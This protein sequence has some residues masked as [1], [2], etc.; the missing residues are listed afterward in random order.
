MICTVYA[1]VVP[2]MQRGTAYA[3]AADGRCIAFTADRARMLALCNDVRRYNEGVR[4]RVLIE[5][6]DW[7][8]VSCI[9][10]S[11]CFAHLEAA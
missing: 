8:K 7:E 2:P 3:H 5:T 6:H 9:A 11:K 1:V 4:G 10:K